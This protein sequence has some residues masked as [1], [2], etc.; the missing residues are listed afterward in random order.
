MS[1]ETKKPAPANDRVEW[2]HD[3]WH[4]GRQFVFLDDE[5]YVRDDEKTPRCPSCGDFMSKVIVREVAP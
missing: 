2:H 1:D 4:A 3:C 5:A